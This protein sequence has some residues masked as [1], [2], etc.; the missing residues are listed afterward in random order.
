M[1]DPVALEIGLLKVVKEDSVKEVRVKE[2]TSPEDSKIKVKVNK[3]RAED[4]TEAPDKVADQAVQAVDQVDQAPDKTVQVVD[5]ADQAADKTVQVAVADQAVKEVV[6]D[7][8][9]ARFLVR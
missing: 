7:I 8:P 9:T 4:T 5:R 3:A 1:E 2:A 6:V